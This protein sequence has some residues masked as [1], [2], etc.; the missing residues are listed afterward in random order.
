MQWWGEAFKSWTKLV[1]AGRHTIY[2]W[3]CLPTLILSLWYLFKILLW[4]AG[5][6]VL[7]V[8]GL[9]GGVIYLISSVGA[10]RAA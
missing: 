8:A 2:A 4:V 6:G 3:G 5:V 10:R 7:C 1:L 9:V